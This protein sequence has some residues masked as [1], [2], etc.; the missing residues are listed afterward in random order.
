MK[1]TIQY[2]VYTANPYERDAWIWFWIRPQTHN[3]PEDNKKINREKKRLTWCQ[4]IWKGCWIWRH[5][6]FPHASGTFYTPVSTHSIVCEYIQHEEIMYTH[7][8]WA[9]VFGY[10]YVPWAYVY[11]SDVCAASIC[12]WVAD[13]ANVCICLWVSV[14]AA[15]ICLCM[16]RMCCEHMPVY[17]TYVLWAYVSE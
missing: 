12:L 16:W 1:N 14:C 6:E 8:P 15:S 7:I 5:F 10:L 3:M 17:V 4:S 2:K 9:Y 11:V 13:R